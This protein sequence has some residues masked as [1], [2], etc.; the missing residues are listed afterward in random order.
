MK[1]EITQQITPLGDEVEN[2]D[3]TVDFIPNGKTITV[4]IVDIYADE[5]YLFRN[6]ITGIAVSRHITI[7]GNDSVENYE[8]V[9]YGT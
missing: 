9:K 6:K 2:A 7:G 5:G 3:G 8:E 1:I 4:E